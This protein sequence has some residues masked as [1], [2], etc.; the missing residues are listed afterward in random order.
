MTV[1]VPVALTGPRHRV[2]RPQRR[3]VEAALVRDD[4]PLVTREL[5]VLRLEPLPLVPLLP[6]LRDVLAVAVVGAAPGLRHLLLGEPGPGLA[7]EA[8][9]GRDLL[10]GASAGRAV[11]R[12]CA[13]PDEPLEAF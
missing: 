5:R 13:D 7:E 11:R 3:A 8:R 6:Q 10:R 4:G 9:A 2:P 1:A 12:G